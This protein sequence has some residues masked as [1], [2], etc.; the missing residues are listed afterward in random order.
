MHLLV[1]FKYISL[2]VINNCDRG[3][4]YWKV[5]N[6]YLS[7]NEYIILINKAID[8]VI[9][10][11]QNVS[12]S[13]LWELCKL[14]IKD[15]SILFAKQKAKER[16]NNLSML[17]NNLKDLNEKEDQ[18]I[19]INSS[20]KKDLEKEIEEIYAF[21]SVGAQ[22]RSRTAFLENNELNPKLFLGLEK[23][24]QTR[25]VLHKLT[26]NG[27][28]YS[29]INDILSQEKLFYEKLYSSENIN[30]MENKQYLNDTL[31]IKH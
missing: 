2:K 30:I 15:K 5:N 16:R 28:Q 27:K 11:Y 29:E 13:L 10:K 17:E 7:N 25:K 8:S 26:V 14:E 24:R 1:T 21:K 6:S 19:P 18:N 4:S 23:S 22:I 9:N 3:K 12:H 31:L 20:A